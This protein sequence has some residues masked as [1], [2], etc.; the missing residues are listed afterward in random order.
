[1]RFTSELLERILPFG[2]RSQSGET[3]ILPTNINKA[4]MSVRIEKS[5]LS[6][7]YKPDEIGIEGE[8]Y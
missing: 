4:L 2:I 7:G 5:L 1:M 3:I 6:A 8:E